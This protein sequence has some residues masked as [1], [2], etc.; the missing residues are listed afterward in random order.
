MAFEKLFEPLRIGSVEIKN[1]Y[2]MA[3]ICC[4]FNDWTGI[5]SDE[6]VACWV[7]RAKGGAGLVIVGSVLVTELGKKVASHPWIYMTGIE[8]V[9][10]LSLLAESLHLC[11]AKAVVQILASAGSRSR[12]VSGEQPVAPSAGARYFYEENK[13]HAKANAELEN[14]LLGRHLKQMFASPYPKPREITEEE[15]D[16]VVKEGAKNAKLAVL[17]GFDGIEIHACHHYIVDQFRDPRYNKRT[18]RYGGGRENRSR[19]L[20][21]LVDTVTRSVKEERKDFVVGVRVGS[22]CEGGYAFD[23]TKWLSG[24]LQELGIDYWHTTYGFPPTPETSTDSKE[25]GGFLRW[26]RELKKVL[27]ILVLTPSV[28]SPILAEDAVRKGWTDMITLARPLLAD[29][30]LPNKVKE[31]R[32]QSIRRCKKDSYCWVTEL[33]RLPQRCSVNPELGREKYNPKYQIREGFKGKEVL[34]YVL[35]EFSK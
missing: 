32:I 21:E 10:R 7:A 25:D 22:E 35:R 31:G 8:H 27:K 19:F 2:G 12:P 1:R 28:H 33:L 15:I 14:R 34:P 5:V 17:A 16:G 30:E 29:P 3:P 9:P 23:E 24:R 13:S 20:I 4:T 6:D 18:D 11:G 26:S